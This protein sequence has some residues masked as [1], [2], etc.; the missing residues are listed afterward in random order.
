MDQ[1]LAEIA[2]KR[3]QTEALLAHAPEE[4]RKMIRRGDLNHQNAGQDLQKENAANVDGDDVEEE[5]LDKNESPV[6][7]ESPTKSPGKNADASSPDIA[8]TST[9]SKTSP[10]KSKLSEDEYRRRFRSRGQPIR[11]F[12]ETDEQRW[13]RLKAIELVDS[14]VQGQRN[15]YKDHAD[16]VDT[17]LQLEALKGSS[18]N[19]DD[20]MDKDKKN[21]AESSKLDL[22]IER[23]EP[24]LHLLS[25][26]LW[27]REPS[28]C[29][30]LV[31]VFWKRLLRFWE[32]ELEKREPEEKRSYQVR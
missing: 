22:L 21:S 20:K 15:I 27:Q 7:A 23:F 29:Y 14:E 9:P 26:D 10:K 5:P 32:E 8:T 17:Q 28:K 30:T 6:T 12:G 3:K 16:Q 11:L 13:E 18:S 19:A 31:Y 1:I 2:R 24:E 4:S 25:I